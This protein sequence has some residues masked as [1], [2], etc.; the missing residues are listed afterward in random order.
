MT[1]VVRLTSEVYD[2]IAHSYDAQTCLPSPELEAHR[3]AF[4]SLV[5]GPVADLGCG[6]GRDLQRLSDVVGMDRSDGMLALA[7]TRGRVVR[8]DLREPPFRDL[9]GV[10]SCASLLH[11]PRPEAPAAL[12]A[13]RSCLRPGGV[14][15]LS[16]SIG[17]HEGWE[18][19]PYAT[20][21]GHRGP[22][23]RWFV[24]HPE[25]VLLGLL[26]NAGFTVVSTSRRT[27][28]RDWLMVLATT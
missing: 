17:D 4:R 24:H 20:P 8:G 12:A 14:L 15:G 23:E 11:V 22:D 7:R 9:S 25:D 2:V 19:V 18:K 28:K 6:P 21:H 27:T 1:D 5:D 26:R 10:W 16:T 13:W 3:A